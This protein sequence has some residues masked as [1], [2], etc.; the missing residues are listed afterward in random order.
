[1]SRKPLRG[2]RVLELGVF[3]SAPRC[4]R[5]LAEQGAEVIKVEPPTGEPMRMLM[6]LTGAER[7]L[8]AINAGKRG[9]T[10]NLKTEQ[11]Q[12]LLRDLCQ[13]SDV[14]LEN[15]VPGTLERL[16]LGYEALHQLNPRLIYASIS[17]FGQTGPL[18]DRPAFDIIA[19]AT[20]GIMQATGRPDR[21]PPIFF[22]DLVSGAYAA[23]AIGFALFDRERT[24]AGRRVDISMQDVMYA[25]HF[26]AHTER[27]LGAAAAQVEAI[28]GR[29]IDR[30]ISDPERPLPFWNSYQAK[31]GY[32]AVVALTDGQW[33]RL[34]D[35]IGQPELK[36]DPRFSNFVTRVKNAGDGV[37]IIAG[38][39]AE[40]SVAE[41]V[42]LLTQAR[43]PCGAVAHKEQVNADPQLQARGMLVTADSPRTGPVEIPGSALRLDP[44]PEDTEPI[45]HPALGEHTEAVL[46][47]LL[48]LSDERIAALRKARAI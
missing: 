26:S 17:G 19:Q 9:V 45:P 15:H 41:V 47:E 30:L 48:G 28:L 27:A 38:F 29:S 14:L 44:E 35:A 40:R 25:H 4:G 20:S 33:Q 13:Q 5:I 24:G 42:E 12:Q 18:C 16:G 46:A 34:M 36:T 22:A 37:A 8:A 23:T 31:D 39:I 2:I 43:V 1:M 7:V 32:V 11:G 6:T 10:I 21:P 3:L